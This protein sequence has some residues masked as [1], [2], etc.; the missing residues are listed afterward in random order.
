MCSVGLHCSNRYPCLTALWEGIV[1]KGV[2]MS[3]CLP[4]SL[5]VSDFKKKTT[6]TDRTFVKLLSEIL[7]VNREEA[8][9]LSKSSASGSQWRNFLKDVSTLRDGGFYHTVAPEAVWQ[10]GRRHT[11]PMKFGQLILRKIV[12]F[13]ATRC[14][15]FT[16]KCTKIHVSRGSAPDPVESVQ[17]PQTLSSNKGD[18][19]LR[20]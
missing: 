3:V 17:A 6:D 16:L 5:F 10:L 8:F 18:L 13:V 1:I 7:S 14:Q 20:D 2:C 11:N 9:K 15:I 12:K 19:L 4:V